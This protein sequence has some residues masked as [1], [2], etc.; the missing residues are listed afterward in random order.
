[1]KTVIKDKAEA[2]RSAS[3]AYS[4]DPEES[5]RQAF[6]SNLQALTIKLIPMKPSGLI[7]YERSIEPRDTGTGNG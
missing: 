3:D 7:D 1:M 6:E 4:S 2:Y 5:D